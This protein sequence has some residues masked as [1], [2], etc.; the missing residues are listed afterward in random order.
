MQEGRVLEKFTTF[1]DPECL[2]TEKITELTGITDEMLTGAPSEREAVEAFL[3]FCGELPLIAHNAGYDLSMMKAACRRLKLPF[4]STCV[5]TLGLAYDLLPQLTKRKL[6]VLAEYFELPDFAHHRATDDAV[7]CGLLFERFAH[8]LMERGVERLQQVDRAAATLDFGS[9][10][11]PKEQRIHHILLLAKNSLGLRNLYRL[12]SF[13][14]LYYFHTR[15]GG[16]GAPVIPKSELARWREGLIVGSAC[17]AGEL[18][19]AIVAG[20][21]Q[22][23]LERI[24]AFY[25]F[26]EIQPL[27]NNRFL[28]N[29]G[30]AASEEELR[31]FNRSVVRLGETLHKPVCA[32]GDVHFLD[33][34]DEIYR[35]ILLASKGF[36]DCDRPNPLY[37]RTTDEMLQEFAYLGPEKAREVVVTNPNRIA[38]M[39]DWVRPLPH[40]LYAPKIENSV[41]DL[42]SL[43]RR[44]STSS[45]APPAAGPAST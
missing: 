22:A 8:M 39:C 21:P 5:D 17:E 7:T 45:P 34:E 20:K 18:F 37:F 10:P 38:D 25:D 24:A 12:V 4:R 40:N 23:E 35:R 15:R 3:N 42:K 41:E 29:S 9:H 30:A 26:L 2:L 28:L 19:S 13:S 32:T 44:A 43:G 27:D 14:N 16:N 11:T 6:D 1:V 33:P 31:D 36:D